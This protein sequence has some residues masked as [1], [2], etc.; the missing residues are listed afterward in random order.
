MAQRVDEPPMEITPTM[1]W[2]GFPRHARAVHGRRRPDASPF[3]CR[4]MESAQVSNRCQKTHGRSGEWREAFLHVTP[5]VAS[6]K[7]TSCSSTSM[8]LSWHIHGCFV[9]SVF[10]SR[11]T[12]VQSGL[13][14]MPRYKYSKISMD[15]V[16]QSRNASLVPSKCV[17]T[18]VHYTFHTIYSSSST[19][20]GRN[21][22]PISMLARLHSYV[23][24]EIITR[25]VIVFRVPLA[26]YIEQGY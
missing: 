17:A 5:S 18:T 6:P 12:L 2:R 1:L 19:R 10:F 7:R 3:V 25:V 21:C 22:K 11:P 9:C 20:L 24:V 15:K 14:P 26:K 16:A 4:M 8:I 23:C 13:L